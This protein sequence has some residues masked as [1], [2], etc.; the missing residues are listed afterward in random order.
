MTDGTLFS[1]DG[2]APT[3]PDDGDYY[4]A[5]GARVIGNVILHKGASIW[6]NAV[7]RGDGEP[8]EIGPDSNVQDGAVIH[9]DPGFPVHVGASVTV[10]HKAILHG[11]R[12]GDGALIGMG[13]TVLNGAEL[14]AGCL[15]GA[16]ALVTEGKVFEDR[17]MLV[18]A[19]ARQLRTLSPQDA[20][21]LAGGAAR[22]RANM[23]RFRKGL[24]PL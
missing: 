5:P 23:T 17:A 6:F 12:I 20:E 11:C 15:V 21:T 14:G 7:L 10:G 16:N 3:L 22:Y 18:G 8:I 4:I 9:T 1:L 19:P 13:A 2:V 24:K